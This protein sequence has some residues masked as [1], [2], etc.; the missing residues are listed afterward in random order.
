MQA[1]KFKFPRTAHF[2][3]LGTPSKATK[4]FWI[5]CHGYGQLAKRFIYKFDSILDEETFVIAPEGFSRFYFDRSSPTPVGSSWMTKEDRLDEI[6]DYANLIQHYYDHY[7]SLMGEEVQINLFGF[8]QGAA[9]QLRWIM[10]KFPR[11]DH[12]ILWAGLIPE[13]LDYQPHQAYFSDKQ[14]HFIYGT[15]DPLI[16]PERIDKHNQ[17]IKDQ[18][19]QVNVQTFEGKH[20]VDRAMLKGLNEQ[21][22]LV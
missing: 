17:L 4:N 3:T 2:Y 22:K 1:H 15:E 14:I 16:T 11:F 18:L 8:S 9:T 20:R 10:E 6:E 13:D 19:L 12:L 21:I 5:V 7:R